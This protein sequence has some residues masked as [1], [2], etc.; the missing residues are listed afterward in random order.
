MIEQSRK[1]YAI[2][3]ISERIEVNKTNP[4]NECNICHFWYF[5]DISFKYEPYFS[6]SNAKSF[7][8]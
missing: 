8:F 5:K 3:D 4:S 1:D 6:W 2:T 7:E